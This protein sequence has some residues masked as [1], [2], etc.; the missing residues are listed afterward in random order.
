VPIL[1]SMPND[2]KK[3]WEVDVRLGA[4]PLSVM[5]S[6]LL[7]IRRDV[8]ERQQ[9]E[10]G[11]SKWG[12]GCCTHE[13]YKYQVT[14]LAGTQGYEWLSVVHVGQEFAFAINGCPMRQFKGDS[15]EPP[16]R[17]LERAREQLNLF[18][19]LAVEDPT[20]LWFLVVET[21]IHGLGVRVVVVQANANGDTRYRWVAAR[22]S[23]LTG[24]FGS[25][26]PVV[27]APIYPTTD[28]PPP[29]VEPLTSTEIEK[30]QK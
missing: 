26:P 15:A 18:P 12:L 30:E 21:D 2:D 19:T 5:G 24:D 28:S 9:P 7:S 10:R 13:R 11:D 4:H 16:T 3:P 27:P 1:R 25:T 8:S 22:A 20:W 14:Q 6:L 29:V 17:Q 23:D